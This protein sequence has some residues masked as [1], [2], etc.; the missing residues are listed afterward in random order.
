[1]SAPARQ[2]IRPSLRERLIFVAVAGAAVAI[3]L[4]SKARFFNFDG[5]DPVEVIRNF[6]YIA[7]ARNTGGVFGIFQEHAV[8]LA[9]FS[10][11]A[12]AAIVV[13]LLMMKRREGWLHVAFGLIVGGAVGNLY[14]RLLLGVPGGGAHFVRDFLD[15]VVFNWHYPTFNA[16]DAF[17]CAGAAMVVLRVLLDGHKKK[18]GPE[19]A[20]QPAA[21]RAKG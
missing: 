4:W 15:V 10:F 13:I 12:L 21:R 17:I 9:V 18:R 16:A 8:L 3:D 14:D 5:G 11:L 2:E 6:F 19:D 20:K 7:S 1:V